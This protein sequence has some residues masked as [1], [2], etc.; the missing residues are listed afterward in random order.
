MRPHEPG[1]SRTPRLLRGWQGIADYLRVHPATATRWHKMWGLP[2]SRIHR[3]GVMTTTSLI[4][5]WIVTIDRIQREEEPGYYAGGPRQ[6][7]PNTTG[8]GPGR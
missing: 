5:A 7:P 8:M 4:D 6:R 2:V 3:S 1:I